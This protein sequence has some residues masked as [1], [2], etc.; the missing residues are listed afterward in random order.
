ML[1]DQPIL[2]GTDIKNPEQNFDNG[3]GESGQP[4]VS[5]DFTGHGASMWS[6]FTRKLSQ[7]GQEFS[8]GAQGDASNQHFAIAL[9]NELISVPQIQWQQYP[10]G[11]AAAAARGSPAASPS[12]PPS[13]WPTC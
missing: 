6:K 7:R 13:S 2:G 1:E 8:L 4:N 5:F 12:S 9:D 11:L 10:N 3:P